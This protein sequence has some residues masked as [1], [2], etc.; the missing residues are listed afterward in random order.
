MDDQF[1]GR[2][3][4]SAFRRRQARSPISLLEALEDE[5][6][7]I[8]RELHDEVGQ[9]LTA[10]H[11][12]LFM[13]EKTPEPLSPAI[14]SKIRQARRLLEGTMELVHDFSR[15]LRPDLLD[16]LGLVPAIRSML[17]EFSRRYQILAHMETGGIVER[18]GS[19]QKLALF[20]IAQEGLTNVARH[21]RATEVKVRFKNIRRGIQMEIIDNGQSFAQELAPETR[22][23]TRLGLRGIQERVRLVAGSFALECRPGRGTILRV[24]VP[25][26][27][28]Q[29]TC[30]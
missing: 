14:R 24:S 17:K 5:R 4:P 1:N 25:F 15:Q 13:L 12:C 26:R 21:A 30:V 2:K 16:H 20:R 9:S 10:I 8:S 28:G 22:N 11:V 6:K 3:A 29:S 23:N 27:P 7:R 18:L 19:E